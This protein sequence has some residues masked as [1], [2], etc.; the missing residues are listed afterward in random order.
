MA[1]LPRGTVTFLFTDIEGSTR[2]LQELGDRYA[3]ALAEHRRVLREAFARHGGV[4]V[5]TQG[6]AFFVAFTRAFDAIAAAEEAQRGLA[7]GPI[8]VR[9]GLHTGE[10]LLTEEGY[11]GLDVHRAARIAAVGHGGQVVLSERTRELAEGSVALTEL[12]RHRLKDLSEPERLYQ[13]GAA[14]FP[15]LR[16]LNATNLPVQPT[17]LVGREREL[18]EALALLH[19]EDVRLLTLAGPGGTGKTRLALQVAAELVDEFKDGVFW[20]S[21][22]ALSEPEFVVPTVAQTLGARELPGEPIDV[23]LASH[24][25]EKRMLLLL[26]NFE[27]VLEAAPSL[28]ELLSHC[29][30]LRLLVTSRAVLRL[31]AEHEYQVPPLPDEDTVALFSERARAIRPDFTPDAAVEQICRRLDGLPLAVELAAARIRLLSPAELLERLS[32]R[33]PLLTGG[34][35]D[36]PARQQTLRA[37]I[38][39]SHNLLEPTEQALF[40]RLSVFAGSFALESAEEVCDADLE[41]LSML[42]EHSLVRRWGSGRFGMLET[43]REFAD[44]RLK[45]AGERTSVEGRLVDAALEFALAAEPQWRMADVD[46]WLSRF[47]L[48]RDNLRRAIR[49]ALDRGDVERALPVAAYLGWLWQERGLL[50]EGCEWHERALALARPGELEP[51]L[52]G[53][54]NFSL[55]ALTAE[56]GDSARGEELMRRGLPL[57][58]AGGRAQDHALAL[59]YL[60]LLIA[61][62]DADDAEELLRQ[63]ELE[64]RRLGDVTLIAGALEGLGHCA[65]DRGDR[66]RA[67]TL[68]EEALAFDRPNPS[69]RVVSL[70][71]LADILIV[72]GEVEEAKRLL[73]EA[74]AISEQAGY[75]RELAFVHLS[76]GYLELA[77]GRRDAAVASLSAAHS[78]AE[79]SGARGV[80]GDTVLG[81]AGVEA[82]WGQPEEAVR[83]WSQARALGA[84]A[85]D[86]SRGAGRS[87]EL[88]LLE[89]LRDR[90]GKE[91]FERVWMAA[92]TEPAKG[93]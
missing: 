14:E 50:E 58:A 26:D 63:S 22:A 83:L 20:V 77:R 72:D 17:A 33:L 64:A 62:R 55:G 69:H 66:T 70:V 46:D 9:I 3:A 19:R 42:V 85:G 8:R 2:L 74:L 21:L 15:P 11:V 40:A 47:D 30:N 18:A 10:P 92:Q 81:C 27:Q 34:A 25:D 68:C 84:P 65:A 73:D 52:E 78:I 79:E 89:P 36:L 90:L 13:L 87:L 29:P 56:R 86:E 91:A 39:W 45:D 32:T 61:R 49:I 80:L 35:R 59:Y 6:D 41:T 76:R 16:S 5:D 57:L 75:A 28:G 51:G 82:R 31:A 7:A 37:T 48:E 1:E 23:T 88:Q 24:I 38:E 53:Y 93:G 60:G 4:E 71:N 43:I 44:E 54:A 67:R 12:G